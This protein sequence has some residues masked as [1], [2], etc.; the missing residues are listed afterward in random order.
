MGNVSVL[1]VTKG[2]D[3]KGILANCGFV[4]GLTAGRLLPT[5][6]FGEDVVDGDGSKHTFLTNVGHN[7]REAGQ[8]KLHTLREEFSKTPGLIVVD[9]TEDAAPADYATYTEALKNHKGEEIVYRAVWIYG[10]AEIVIPKTK[11][12]S[13]LQ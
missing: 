1:I 7:V 9:Y 6:T 10:P 4:L 11:N 12:L 5:E 8:S 13:A 2:V 3:H